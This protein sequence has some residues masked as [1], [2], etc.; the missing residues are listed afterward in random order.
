MEEETSEEVEEAEEARLAKLVSPGDKKSL[1]Q[2]A[3]TGLWWDSFE[4]E[5][6]FELDDDFE[7]QLT[8]SEG[9]E[10]E[11]GTGEEGRGGGGGGES[12][13]TRPLTTS[14]SGEAKGLM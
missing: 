10:G 1:Y 3:D 2:L 9:E 13:L 11:E 4:E 8:L 7:S 12:S 6:H 5:P 14:Q